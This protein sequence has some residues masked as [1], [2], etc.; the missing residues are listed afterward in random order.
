MSIA[1]ITLALSSQ[2][3]AVRGIGLL[4]ALPWIGQI[5]SPLSCL[6]DPEGPKDEPVA[7][8]L[9]L[10]KM[11]R[12]HAAENIAD[13]LALTVPY[14]NDPD[15][16]LGTCLFTNITSARLI[17]INN[18]A[19]NERKG[20]GDAQRKIAMTLLDT[21]RVAK[22]IRDIEARRFFLNQIKCITI[23]PWQNQKGK[24]WSGDALT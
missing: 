19:K 16:F 5:G 2:T 11:E 8:A 20:S 24:S 12:F 7:R 15:A 14:S 1:N 21:A 13:G 17:D 10:I 18:I 22:K 23:A 6:I 9:Q 4:G 3:D